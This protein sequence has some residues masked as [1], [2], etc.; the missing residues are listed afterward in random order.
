MTGPAPRASVSARDTAAPTAAAPLAAASP[1]RS[2]RLLLRLAALL[3]LAALAPL[4]GS[5]CAYAKARGRDF[6]QVFRFEIGPALNF[7]FD[8]RLLG[9]LDLGLGGGFHWDAGWEYGEGYVGK[10]ETIVAPGVCLRGMG[11]TYI[12]SHECPSILPPV[13]AQERFTQ[14]TY[15]HMGS[16]VHEFDLEVCAMAAI[17]HF[18]F[19]FSPGQLFDAFAGVFGFDPAGDDQGAKPEPAP[20]IPPQPERLRPPPAGPARPVGETPPDGQEYRRPSQPERVTPRRPPPASSGRP[21]PP[22][23]S[24]DEDGEAVEPKAPPRQK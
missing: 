24:G 11:P 15:T 19:G 4:A 3:L 9:L 20:D 13:F 7:G 1:P 22:A 18:R 14:Q 17:L 16:L 2:P 23:S 12:W 21:T 5:G 6:S 10:Q 8:T